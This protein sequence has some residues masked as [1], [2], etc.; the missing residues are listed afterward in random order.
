ME[1]SNQIELERVLLVGADTGE[2]ENFERSMEELASL[3]EACYMEP[4]GVITQKMES[5]NKGLY[6]GTGKVQEVKEAAQTLE[7]EVV[8]FDNALTPSQLRNLQTQLELPI[9]DRTTLILNIFEERAK[10]REAKLQV[11]VAV[12][13]VRRSWSWTDERL[14]IGLRSFEKNWK[15]LK[16]NARYKEKEGK[17]PEFHLLHW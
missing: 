11:E 4:V 16:K 9:L 12:E 10:T 6:I 15:I 8:I 7:A 3:A 2:D 5:I 13:L 17:T 1:E 14:N